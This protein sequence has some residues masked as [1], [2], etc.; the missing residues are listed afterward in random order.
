MTALRDG[1]KFHTFVA[2]FQPKHLHSEAR[3]PKPDL[4]LADTHLPPDTDSLRVESEGCALMTLSGGLNI[5]SKE[6][7]LTTLW[8]A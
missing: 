6:T 4:L 7:I 8:A 3:V 5:E 1:I 2:T